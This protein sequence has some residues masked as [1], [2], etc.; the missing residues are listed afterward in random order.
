MLTGLYPQNSN[1]LEP[2]DRP[3]RGT[4]FLSEAIKRARPQTVTAEYSANG[5]VS[6]A[7]GFRYDLDYQRNMIREK[8]PNRSRDLLDAWFGVWEKERVWSSPFMVWLGTTDAH[9]AYDPERE[10]LNLYDPEPYSGPINPYRT[11]Y[12]M[13][14][15]SRGR[16]KL[17]ERDWRRLLALY[18]GEVSYNDRQFGLMLER[19]DDWGI[20]DETAVIIVSD[21]GEEFLDHGAAGHG[22]SL[23]SEIVHVPL[24]VLYPRGFPE[25][26]RIDSPVE[27]MSIYPTILELLDI[28]PPSGI[29][30]A[31]LLPLI[32]GAETP[33]ARVAASFNRSKDASFTVGRHR[34]LLE[35]GR[36]RALFDEVDDPQDRR[37]LRESRKDVLYFMF[38]NAAQWMLEKAP[39]TNSH[40]E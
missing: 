24:I 26:R 29:D 2:D 18:N 23:Y 17:T 38:K 6:S 4:L 22:H 14:D 37:D 15:I 39:R 5:Y 30:A 33:Q 9:V 20:L 13:A 31:S 8:R 19:L 11:A 21:H 28:A 10:F 25:A 35:H 27:M 32:S 12:I 1:M 16:L 3:A 34:L 40:R 36:P 7:F